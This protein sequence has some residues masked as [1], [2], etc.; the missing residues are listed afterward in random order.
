MALDPEQE[1]PTPDISVA[2]IAERFV[3]KGND[4]SLPY[5]AILDTSSGTTEPLGADTTLSYF[6]LLVQEEG[7]MTDFIAVAQQHGL[8]CITTPRVRT[9]QYGII[10]LLSGSQKGIYG[11]DQA[12][13]AKYPP[14]P[15]DQSGLEPFIG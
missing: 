8:A 11:E 6:A 9:G 13:D 1:T 10:A 14:L 3:A 15:A 4:G 5:P 12:D 7:Q 2:L